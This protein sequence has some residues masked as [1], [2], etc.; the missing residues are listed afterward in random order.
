M[1]TVNTVALTSPSATVSYRKEIAAALIG[2]AF[3]W[4]DFVIYGYFAA[5]LGQQLFPPGDETITLL[6]V[7]ASFGVG[8]VARPIGGLFFGLLADRHGRKTALLLTLWLMLLGTALT[9]FAP[10]YAVAG[11]TGAVMIVIGRLMQG[12]GA[13]GEYGSA[14]AFLVEKA[15]HNRRNFF[16]S[17]QM[18]SS[19]LGI[20]VAGTFG[21][22]LASLLSASH[23]TSWGW[24]I[25]FVFGLLIGPVGYYMRRHVNETS[26]FRSA[27]RIPISEVLSEL[28][29]KH[30]KSTFAALCLTLACTTAFYVCIVY[31]PTF[32]VRELKLPANVSFICTTVAALILV[33]LCPIAGYI[34]DRAIEPK[35]LFFIGSTILALICYPLF[36]LT[37]AEPSLAHLLTTLV[38]MAIPLGLVSGLLAPVTSRIFPVEIRS[39]GLALTY[40]LPTVL[41]GFLPLTMTYLIS[42][43]GNRAAPAFCILITAILGATG[44]LLL[45]REKDV[46]LHSRQPLLDRLE[47]NIE[48]REHIRR[49]GEQ[50]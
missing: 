14:V 49:V 20:L 31:M 34:A 28:F 9:A 19:M 47:G 2:N 37:I 39:T 13:S 1:P 7:F 25:P 27:Q 50:L 5:I 43:T 22:A 42:S 36:D 30:C 16:T 29:G 6:L 38:L 24:R 15:P 18:A 3:E 4:Y 12:F 11:S 10:A 46:S 35:Y 33:I 21:T 45:R 8:F 26:A 44:S 17:L 32:A 41:S 40:N 48:C 23:L